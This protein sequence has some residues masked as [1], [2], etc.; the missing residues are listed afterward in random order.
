MSG[1][2]RKQVLIALTLVLVVAVAADRFGL[3]D[4]MGGSGSATGESLE[5]KAA[6]V[7]SQEALVAQRSAWERARAEANDA[8][9]DLGDRVI[10]GKTVQ[11]AE[12]ELKKLASREMTNIG[13]AIAGSDSATPGAAVERGVRRVGVVL[14]LVTDDPAKVTQLV[15]RLENL[16]DAVTSVERVKIVGPGSVPSKGSV[17]A[18]ITLMGLAMIDG[19]QGGEA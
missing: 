17:E 11:I 5:A 12:D 19:S 13:L 15:D 9:G 4:R 2:A 16:S 10:R 14:S 6:L 18:T 1:E 7:A 3:I 8:L